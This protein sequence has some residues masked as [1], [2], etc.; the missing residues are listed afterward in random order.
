MR[1]YWECEQGMEPEDIQG[2]EKPKRKLLFSIFPPEYDFE[3]MLVNQ[4]ESTVKGVQIFITWL[5]TSPMTDPVS[6][7]LYESQID[8]MRHAMEDKLGEAFSTPFDRQD[9][10]SLSRQIGYV[11]DFTVVTA[12]EMHAFGVNP[13]QPILQMAEALLTGAQALTKGVRNLH[14]DERGLH[15]MIHEVREAIRSIEHVYIS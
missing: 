7:D 12:R 13:D 1:R 2:R 9:I 10:Y 14:G 6:L 3:G 5:Q 4:A 8:S 11:L 15:D